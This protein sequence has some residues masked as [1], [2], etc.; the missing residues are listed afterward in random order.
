MLSEYD[1]R[2]I[3]CG[4]C[5]LNFGLHAELL[6]PGAHTGR[7]FTLQHLERIPT[8]P[9]FMVEPSPAGCTDIYGAHG[10]QLSAFKSPWKRGPIGVA[11]GQAVPPQTHPLT[12]SLAGVVDLFTS[13]NG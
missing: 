2:T 10:P 12:G 6:F 3:S 13:L 11:A 5:P 9:P 1:D 7:D 8:S 4:L